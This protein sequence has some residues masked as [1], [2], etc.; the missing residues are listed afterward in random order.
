MPLNRVFLVG[1]MGAGKST[2]GKYL[3]DHL[4]LQFADTDTEIEARTGADIPWIFDVEGEEGF[5][6]REQQVVE[7]MTLWDD[8]VL[9]TGGGVVMRPENRRALGARGYVIY[10]YASLDEQVRRTRKDRKRPL[11]QTGDPEQVLRDLFAIRDPFY[12]EIA[13]HVIETD[14]CSPRTVAQRLVKQLAGN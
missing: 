3:A 6:D 2:I 8:V 9:A 1:P 10:L 13:D 12:R 5:R 4:K 11:L 14:G 7:E